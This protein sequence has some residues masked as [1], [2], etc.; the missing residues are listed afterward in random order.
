M[1][2]R[3]YFLAGDILACMTAGAAGAWLALTVIPGDWFA[4]AA[5]GAGMIVGMGAGL[6]GAVLFTPFFGAFEIMLPSSLAGMA[7]GMVFGM[8][9]TTGAIGWT[10]AVW[11]GA[12][13]G[14]LCLMM[15]YLLQAHLCGEVD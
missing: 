10:V 4:P 14:L 13:V 15:T 7:A 1:A 8:I 12:L 3:I 9:G 2:W 6:A 5:M 11:G